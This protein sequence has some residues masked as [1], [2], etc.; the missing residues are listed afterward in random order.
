MFMKPYGKM[1]VTTA[2]GERERAAASSQ[3]QQRQ[4]RSRRKKK[5][6]E[7]A[8]DASD[9]RIHPSPRTHLVVIFLVVLFM[10]RVVKPV[11]NLP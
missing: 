11:G 9:R 3:Q 1:V 4:S 7:L 8:E 5:R 10:L 2:G 6:L